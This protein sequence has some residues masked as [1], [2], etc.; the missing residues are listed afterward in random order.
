MRTIENLIK[1]LK[2]FPKDAK[3][4]AYQGECTGISI[5]TKDNKYGFIHVSEMEK[6]DETELIQ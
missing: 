2:K 1:E 5:E 6:E 4:F 3:C